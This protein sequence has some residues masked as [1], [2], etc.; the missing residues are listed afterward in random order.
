MD[1][2]EGIY[3]GSESYSEDPDSVAREPM[4]GTNQF[5]DEKDLPGFA[6]TIRTF[7]NK[8]SSVG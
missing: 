7:L 4:M 3:F 8:M 1:V 2:K 6:A 5:P